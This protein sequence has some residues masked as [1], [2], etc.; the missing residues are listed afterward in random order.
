MFQIMGI[1]KYYVTIERNNALK[2]YEYTSMFTT[3][4]LII[5]NQN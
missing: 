3:L 1:Q 5:Q 2:S 4:M